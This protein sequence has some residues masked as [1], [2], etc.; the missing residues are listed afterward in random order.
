MHKNDLPLNN[1]Q[2][3]PTD[4]D[5]T[6]VFGQALVRTVSATAAFEARYELRRLGESDPRR[7][8]WIWSVRA[9]VSGELPT[10]RLPVGRGSALLLELP[11]LQEPSHEDARIVIHFMDSDHLRLML[12]EEFCESNK[13]RVIIAE[14]DATVAESLK[15]FLSRHGFE[16]TVTASA[17]DTLASIKRETFDL[18]LLDVD[19]HDAHAFSF[20]AQ[21]RSD[22]ATRC[23]RI[24]IS[25][26]WQ[27][28]AELAAKAGAIGYL[29]KPLDFIGL[30]ER[31]H[32][33]LRM[34]RPR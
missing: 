17:A 29:D 1:Q 30:P 18:V 13:P 6:T 9:A 25:S 20:C 7:Y 12:A 2:V 10:R 27:H 19:L 5:L 28:L 23:L 21:L 3:E 15:V 33:F 24:V 22:P 31:L 34:P 11:L 16:I 26:A 8:E 4:V 32:R 14:N